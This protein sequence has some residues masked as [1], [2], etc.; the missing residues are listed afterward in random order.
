MFL[1]VRVPPIRTLPHP[2]PG[3]GE[4]VPSA[5]RPLSALR[6]VF[7]FFFH[8]PKRCLPACSL[9][10]AVRSLLTFAEHALRRISSRPVRRHRRAGFSGGA[11][12]NECRELRGKNTVSQQVSF[13]CAPHPTHT[14]PFWV[15]PKSADT[16]CLPSS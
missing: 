5:P 2:V 12:R 16:F 7:V 13:K 1:L 4:C 6:C 14:L 15:L 3:S 11:L 10:H 9:K 8:P